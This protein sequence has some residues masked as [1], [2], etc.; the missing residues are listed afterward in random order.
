MGVGGSS[1]QVN[2]IQGVE[3]DAMQGLLGTNWNILRNGDIVHVKVIDVPIGKTIWQNDVVVGGQ[4]YV[5]MSG[6]N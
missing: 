4:N 5:G 2:F 3:V 1:G 6:S